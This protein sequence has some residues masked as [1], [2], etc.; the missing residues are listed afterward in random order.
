MRNR[1]CTMGRKNRTKSLWGLY[2]VSGKVWGVECFFLKAVLI[3]LYFP[4]PPLTRLPKA[5][6]Q[7]RKY[8]RKC[9]SSFGFCLLKLKREK[10]WW[11]ENSWYFKRIPQFC[12]VRMCEI[13]GGGTSWG[14]N[15]LCAVCGAILHVNDVRQDNVGTTTAI[16]FFF[17]APNSGEHSCHVKDQQTKI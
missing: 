7:P 14:C 17:L 16:P 10:I 11:E 12:W 9:H 3:K 5:I 4:A 6:V 8:Q 1:I 2:C 15:G 13:E